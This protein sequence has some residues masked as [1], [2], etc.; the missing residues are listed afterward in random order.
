ML[1]WG[2]L[3]SRADDPHLLSAREEIPPKRHPNGCLQHCNHSPHRQ[4]SCHAVLGAADIE[5]GGAPPSVGAGGE[6][7]EEGPSGG[8]ADSAGAGD[9][10]GDCHWVQA[11]EGQCSS[12][13]GSLDARFPPPPLSPQ[14]N[15]ALMV[16]AWTPLPPLLAHT[17]IKHICM[18]QPD[19]DDQ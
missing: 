17:H 2:Q 13:G 14:H 6:T 16:G 19:V 8:S 4:P 10:S 11:A 7:L 12:H 15:A 18:S 9:P 3:T 1:Y 5:G